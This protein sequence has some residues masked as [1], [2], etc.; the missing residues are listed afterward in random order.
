MDAMAR[1]IRSVIANLTE[2]KKSQKILDRLFDVE[3]FMSG[4]PN[5]ASYV[6]GLSVP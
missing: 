4:S 1:T 3:C 5:G 6:S 2:A